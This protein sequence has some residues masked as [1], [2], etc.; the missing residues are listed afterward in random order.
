MLS[1][2][3]FYLFLGELTHIFFQVVVMVISVWWVETLL[4][5][6][7]WRSV[8]T[9]TG[10]LCVI[11]PGVFQMP[12]L[13][14]GSWDSLLKEQELSVKPGLVR[15]LVIFCWMRSG[16]LELR[17]DLLTVLL[18]VLVSMTAHIQKM[19]ESGANQQLILPQVYMYRPF[20]NIRCV[21]VHEMSNLIGQF[22]NTGYRQEGF[23]M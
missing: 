8:T 16:V 6:V 7:V 19:L 17:E 9:T 3:K 1:Q 12:L 11:T 4:K 15:A 13:F 14:A 10:E 5:K 18:A 20:T 21:H 2:S 22:K 23:Y